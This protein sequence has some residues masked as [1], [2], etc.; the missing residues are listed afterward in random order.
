MFTCVV[1]CIGNNAKAQ[2]CCSAGAPLTSVFQIAQEDKKVLR[3][4]LKYTYR[5]INRLV[6]NSEV[7][8][9]DP[10]SRLGNNLLL[11]ADY[12]LSNKFAISLVLPYVFQSRTTFS[13]EQTSDG[14]GDVLL[15]GQ[16]QKKI[17]EEYTLSFSLGLKLPTGRVNQLSSRGVFL[18][19]DMQSGTGTYDFLFGVNFGKRHF[20][21][22]NMSFYTNIL[23]RKNTTNENFGQVG[24]SGGRSFKFGDELIFD[25][26]LAHQQIWG[27]WF[28]TPYVNLQYRTSQANR[29][30]GQESPNSGGE[31]LN[32]Q[33]G[34]QLAPNAVYDF[35]IYGQV[36]IYQELN[37]L[38]ITTDFEVGIEF[39]Y[40]FNLAK[41]KLPSNI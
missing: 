11:K 5:S 33:A 39:N 27:T 23:Y 22:K 40:K 20:L 18:S 21:I 24:N 29:E 17:K 36:P 30:Q 19:P 37:G 4:K 26:T 15:V 25:A 16:Y 9:N 8:V 3:T 10:R 6:E 35:K 13:E 2:T 1:F 14:F 7:L 28:A 41:K 12:T 32:A 31:W 34:L 38:Q